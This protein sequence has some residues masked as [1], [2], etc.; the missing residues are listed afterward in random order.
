MKIK[1]IIYEN[2]PKEA[3]ITDICF[4][5]SEIVI[6]VKSRD[7]FIRNGDVIKQLVG[8]LKKRISVRPDPSISMDMEEAKEKINKI[9]PEEAGIDEITFEPA[10][11]RFTIEAQKPGLV[12]GKG[13]ETLKKIKSETMWFPVVKR[14]PTIPSEVV[15]TI[16]KVIFEESGFRKKFLN[17]LGEKIHSAE[18]KEIEWIR[19]G[20]LG[21]ARE[22][23]RSCL[24]LQTPGSNVILDCGVKPTNDE[25]PYLNA[26]EFSIK[27]LDSIV[28]SHSHLDHCGFIPYL[29]RYGYEGPLYCTA[30]VRDLMVL[31]C[32]DYLEVAQRE[33]H[34]A[35]Y[36]SKDIEAAIKYSIILDY[37]E[38]SD[39]T[40]DMRITF[41]NAGH[42]LG[43]SQ[44]HI[45]IG[46][47]LHN[48]VYSGDINF[49]KSRLFDPAFTQF[50]R[51]ETLILESTYGGEDSMQP[52]RKE[53]EEKLKKIVMDTMKKGGRILIPSFAVGRAQE[54]MCILSDIPNFKYPVYLEGMLWDATAIHTTY[55]EYLN[56]DLQNMIFHR[57]KS[58][59]TDN[60]F[61]RIGST[62]ERNEIL[63]TND[64]F[65][66]IATSGMLVGGP[67][68]EYL[69]A[70]ADDPKNTLIFVGYQAEGTFGRKI[71]KGWKEMPI[72]EN[73]NGKRSVL[74]I[75]ME[76]ET[77]EGLSGHSDRNQLVKYVYKLADKPRKIILN[78]GE[79]GKCIDLAKSLH[80]MFKCETIAPKNLEIIRLR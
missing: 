9:V 13:G 41:Q 18:K 6:Y 61:K 70:F 36:S 78:H 1:E 67:A 57:G 63:K 56:K 10:F 26:P 71:Q 73:G 50:Q 30:P 77:V 51:V 7:F 43:S 42:I 46:E 34:K 19:I 4:E 16:R 53:A 75:K 64:P 45:H 69:K 47:G 24:L 25:F 49:E 20:F 66:V 72:S 8:K 58:P 37:D 44:V 12:I 39:I 32:L 17:K 52:P 21:S 48:I 40:P 27:K 80:R 33:G 3:N 38:V 11:G 62:K 74:E 22:V 2:I 55:P 28:L 76:V 35:P 15:Q 23:G 31:L 29:Y 65:V 5:G 60:I 79:E 68:I 54:V 59:F 14:A